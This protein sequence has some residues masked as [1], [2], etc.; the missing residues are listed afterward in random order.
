MAS[1][2]LDPQVVDFISQCINSVEQCEILLLLKRKHALDADTINQEL[3][4]S[5]SSVEKRLEAL[6]QK[7]L[8][9][10][11]DVGGKIIYEYSPGER[12]QKVVEDLASFYN[13]HRVAIINLIFSKP[14]DPLKD[15]S[16]AFRLREKD[17]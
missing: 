1:S 7:Q 3:R 9:T 4:T 17:T 8:I 11:K 15:F 13:T 6:R 12:Y 2:Q 10:K 14:Q 16:D 5:L